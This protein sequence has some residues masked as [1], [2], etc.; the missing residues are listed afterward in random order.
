[1]L[2]Y[3]A[4]TRCQP[5]G[6]GGRRGMK[7]RG[8]TSGTFQSTET[9]IQEPDR[10]APHRQPQG[11]TGVWVLFRA[12]SRGG[13]VRFPKWGT[14]RHELGRRKDIQGGKGRREAVPTLSPASQG[15]AD[16]LGPRASTP[17]S[18][19][20]GLLTPHRLGCAA[21]H[22]APTSGGPARWSPPF[23]KCI[24]PPLLP[25]TGQGGQWRP[26]GDPRPWLSL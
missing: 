3:A 19:S 1:M 5:L 14:L 12:W 10:R 20:L 11:Q 9:G 18:P 25:G 23:L 2:S 15:A 13:D 22:S 21:P 7:T 4:Y 6:P 8:L 26:G 16:H 17:A 24:S